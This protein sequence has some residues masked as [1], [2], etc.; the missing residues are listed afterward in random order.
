MAGLV[1]RY[2]C[3]VIIFINSFIWQ[4]NLSFMLSSFSQTKPYDSKRFVLHVHLLLSGLCVSTPTLL[5]SAQG[6][7]ELP[8]NGSWYPKLLWWTHHR[9][10]PWRLHWHEESRW[11]SRS[12]RSQSHTSATGPELKTMV[13]LY[14]YIQVIWPYY[15]NTVFTR[16]WVTPEFN[17]HVNSELAIK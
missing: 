15:S 1:Y 2:I 16:F 4:C 5:F 3:L 8:K 11:Q 6:K 12:T 10:E 13:L 7:H 17:F 14:F 9:E